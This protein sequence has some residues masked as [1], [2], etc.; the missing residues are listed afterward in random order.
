M[1][2]VENPTSQPLLLLHSV[3][4]VASKPTLRPSLVEIPEFQ[5]GGLYDPQSP[6]ALQLYDSHM[7]CIMVGDQ[8]VSLPVQWLGYPCPGLVVADAS[9]KASNSCTLPLR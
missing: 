3:P 7:K 1:C 5:G 6:S 9:A 4:A 2:T 8:M